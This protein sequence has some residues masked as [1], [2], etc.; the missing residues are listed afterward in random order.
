MRTTLEI[1]DELLDALMERLPTASK[2]EA[3]AT[4]I[5]AYVSHG[6]VARLRQMAGG[7]DVED[8]SPALRDG[9]RTT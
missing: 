4:A 3:I 1:D 7:V 9:D 5:E 2:T 8:I 6:S